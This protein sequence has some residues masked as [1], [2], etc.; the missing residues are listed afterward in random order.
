M[1]RTII[2]TLAT[3]SLIWALGKAVDS[4]QQDFTKVL[5]YNGRTK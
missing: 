3:L 1:K 5:T 4:I 2:M